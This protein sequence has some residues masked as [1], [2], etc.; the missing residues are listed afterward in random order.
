MAASEISIANRALQKIGARRVESMT[1][2]SPNARTVSAAFAPVRDRLLRNYTWN[3]AKARTQVAADTSET[4]WGGLHR[5][6]KPNDFLRL[7]RGKEAG[8]NDEEAR[9]HWQIEGDYIVSDEDPPLEYVYIRQ[10]TDPAQFDSLFSEVLALTLAV[11]IC[12]EITQ[13]D[14]KKQLLLEEREAMMAEARRV[15]S[16]ENPSQTPPEDDWVLARL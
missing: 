8:T 14:R 9:V 16:L 5:F 4:V 15:N 3:F 7:L 10:V 11:D 2:D 6:R 1:E 13:D 12:D